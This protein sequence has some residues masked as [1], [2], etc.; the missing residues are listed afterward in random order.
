MLKVSENKR[1]LAQED[2]APFFYLGDTAW[3]LFHALDRDEAAYYLEDRAAK[4]FT[5]IQAV[6]ISE[7]DG[8]RVPNRYGHLPLYDLDPTRPVEEYFRHM[9]DVIEKAAS[10]GLVVGLVV[11]GIVLAILVP[12]GVIALPLVI[13]LAVG[14]LLLTPFILLLKLVF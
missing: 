3:E 14:A 11:G 2:G 8:L 6:A 5:V 12:L 4:G 10:L 13:V 1:F 9:D 7:F